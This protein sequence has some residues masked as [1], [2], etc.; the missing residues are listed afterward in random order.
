MKM[1]QTTAKYPKYDDNILAGTKST[2]TKQVLKDNAKQTHYN[3]TK[4]D[5]GT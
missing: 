3:K 5:Y 2:E 4:P 1:T